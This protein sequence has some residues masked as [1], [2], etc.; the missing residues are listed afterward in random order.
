MFADSETL[1][2]FEM[3]CSRISFIAYILCRFKTMKLF[4]E[5][6]HT[7]PLKKGNWQHQQPAIQSDG[8]HVFFNSTV[9]F[10]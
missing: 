7:L 3:K 4:Q 2:P 8:S 1:P 9:S 10:P 5:P 6:R